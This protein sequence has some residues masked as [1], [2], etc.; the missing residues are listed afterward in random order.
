MLNTGQY[1][2]IIPY[3]KT[4]WIH[5]LYDSGRAHQFYHVIIKTALQ[6]NVNIKTALSINGPDSWPVTGRL[7][8]FCIHE[9]LMRLA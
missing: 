7:M 5:R 2:L 3:Q 6:V 9:K 8:K 1:E 4:I